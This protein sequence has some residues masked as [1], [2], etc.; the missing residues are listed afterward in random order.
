MVLTEMIMMVVLLLFI[1]IGSSHRYHLFPRSILITLLLLQLQLL[2]LL[3]QLL[4]LLILL[5]VVIHEVPRR[6]LIAR[7]LIIA[8]VAF[9]AFVF[10]AASTS[11]SA[12]LTAAIAPLIYPK[13]VAVER[14]VETGVL[15]LRLR[16]LLIILGVCSGLFDVVIQVLKILWNWWGT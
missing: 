10:G 1:M 11:I 5:L 6:A 3:L 12:F 7:M 8:L 13:L 9:T 2:L 4:T 16:L 14:P 15:W